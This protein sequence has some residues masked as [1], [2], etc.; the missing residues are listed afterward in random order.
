MFEEWGIYPMLAFDTQ[1]VLA[2]LE[3]FSSSLCVLQAH[4]LNFD[5]S[6]RSILFLVFEL[7]IPLGASSHDGLKRWRYS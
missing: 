5:S 1:C 3:C 6:S 4:E 7:C 2:I